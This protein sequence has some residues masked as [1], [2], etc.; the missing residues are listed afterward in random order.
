MNEPIV[1][2]RTET[3]PGT[4]ERTYKW[5]EIVTP[6]FTIRRMEF[7]GYVAFYVRPVSGPIAWPTDD[8]KPVRARSVGSLNVAA[9]E[10]DELLAAI[11][12]ARE[13]L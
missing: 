2:E 4:E 13:E 3:I 8:P 5:K 9:E 12:N 6:H 1:V 7:Y 10:I 11:T